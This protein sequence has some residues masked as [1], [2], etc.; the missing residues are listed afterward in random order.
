MH[1]LFNGSCQLLFAMFLDKIQLPF[2]DFFSLFF[3][4]SVVNWDVQ[5]IVTMLECLHLVV[6]L[7]KYM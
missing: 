3:P 1:Y 2:V 6:M 7:I 5:N 4:P